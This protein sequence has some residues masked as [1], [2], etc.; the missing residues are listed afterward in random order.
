MHASEVRFATTAESSHD[1]QRADMVV[2]VADGV[3]VKNRLG[4]TRAAAGFGLAPSD[5]P[6]TSFVKPFVLDL[7]K[8]WRGRDWTLQGFGMLRTY[9]TKTLRLHVWNS[10]FAVP[11][12]TTIHDHPWNFASLVVA[13]QI[14][15]TRYRV[16]PC[17][18]TESQIEALRIRQ[19]FVKSRIVCGP[20]GGNDEASL[21]ARGERVWLASS[22]TTLHESGSLYRM[23]ADE[24]HHTTY[25]DGTV[26]LVE[27]EFLQDTEHAHVFFKPDAGW[28]SAEPRPATPDEVEAIVSR[29]LLRF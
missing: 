14:R 23:R 17:T 25:E 9:V 16:Y 4:L 24:V 2:D 19:P 29:A 22:E 1:Q 21:L 3:V 8:N 15:N 27:R 12:V 11:K 6:M 5:V 10:S 18:H 7:L 26:T 13:G 28:V 20:G